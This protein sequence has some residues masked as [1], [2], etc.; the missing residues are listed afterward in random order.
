MKERPTMSDMPSLAGTA[1]RHAEWVSWNSLLF[2]NAVAHLRAWTDVAVE[3]GFISW[4][5]DLWEKAAE[6]SDAI[7]K[8]LENWKAYGL[9]N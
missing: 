7:D 1:R 6:R 8:Q 4:H 3:A 5:A 2:G 9:I